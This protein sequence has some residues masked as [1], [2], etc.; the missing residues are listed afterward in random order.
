MFDWR[1]RQSHHTE[2]RDDKSQ[3]ARHQPQPISAPDKIK[4]NEDKAHP[5][6]QASE[7]PMR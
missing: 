7:K 3:E 4:S 2:P 1:A 5:Q 6:Q